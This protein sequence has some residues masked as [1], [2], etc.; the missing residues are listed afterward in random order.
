MA[1]EILIHR[2]GEKSRKFL[3]RIS[4]IMKKWQWQPTSK[5]GKTVYSGLFDSEKNEIFGKNISILT[6]ILSCKLDNA[7]WQQNAAC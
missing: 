7:I 5:T 6:C 1:P 3:A 2:G 4:E